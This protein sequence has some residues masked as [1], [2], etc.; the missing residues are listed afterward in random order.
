MKNG[1]LHA[2]R[3]KTKVIDLVLK[4]VRILRN[5]AVKKK[6]KETFL[7]LHL[8]T[9][10]KISIGKNDDDVFFLMFNHMKI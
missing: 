1:S 8:F 3:T 10:S 9:I 5:H 6:K 2:K 4:E 7:F